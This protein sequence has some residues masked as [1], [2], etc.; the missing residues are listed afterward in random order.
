MRSDLAALI[1]P[2]VIAVA[3]IAAVLALL[4]REMVPRRRGHMAPPGRPDLPVDEEGQVTS[5]ERAQTRARRRSG[6]GDEG[7]ADNSAMGL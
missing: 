4:R 3:F 5:G 2:L 1:P 7:S 6:D